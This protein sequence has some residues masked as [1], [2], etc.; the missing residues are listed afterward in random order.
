M[1]E[2]KEYFINIRA[3]KCPKIYINRFQNGDLQRMSAIFVYEYM[4]TGKWI[5]N[6]FTGVDTD[7]N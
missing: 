7:V 6:K 5:T 4:N 3:N 2:A 1:V